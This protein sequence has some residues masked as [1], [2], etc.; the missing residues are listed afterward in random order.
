MTCMP[1]FLSVFLSVSIGFCREGF[2]GLSRFSCLPNPMPTICKRPSCCLTVVNRHAESI[3]PKRIEYFGRY[4]ISETKLRF[5]CWFFC[6]FYSSS[7]SF[8][9]RL[10]KVY[11]GVYESFFATPARIL[12]YLLLFL[13]FFLFFLFLCF[14]LVFFFWFSLR[15]LWRLLYFSF[16][17]SA[18]LS[19]FLSF[20]LSFFLS[21]LLSF[22][23]F[24]WRFSETST[25]GGKFWFFTGFSG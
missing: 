10:V 24:F 3:A 20:L 25:S 6:F 8:L 1:Q 18:S 11:F 15:F 13:P 22:L 7:S 9:V 19:F 4:L 23:L 14:V 2:R 21:F 12:V 5:F 16:C 17:L